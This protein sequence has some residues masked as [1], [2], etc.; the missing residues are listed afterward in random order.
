MPQDKSNPP[1]ELPVKQFDAQRYLTTWSNRELCLLCGSQ[2][3]PSMK[4]TSIY[5]VLF[6]FQP[7]IFLCCG[8]ICFNSKCSIG[9]VA[10]TLLQCLV[11][12]QPYLLLG[13]HPL[14]N[15]AMLIGGIIKGNLW[16][17]DITIK[18]KWHAL[19]IK[20]SCGKQVEG[21]QRWNQTYSLKP[22]GDILLNQVRLARFWS[23]IDFAE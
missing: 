15:L 14:G 10:W 4:G 16:R 22:K 1:R 5:N 6:Y 2:V 9:W 8:T 20:N 13:R 23:W 18:F 19:H 7:N 12:G 21:I 3:T 17:F 11:T